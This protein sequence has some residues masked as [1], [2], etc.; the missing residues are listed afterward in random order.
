LQRL[1]ASRGG[2]A[3]RH[4]L[5]NLGD[6]LDKETDFRWVVDY[7]TSVIEEE[8]DS[9]YWIFDAVRKQQQVLNFRN[10]FS[11]SIY[12]I[13]FVAPEAEL[14]RRYEE[15]QQF[16]GLRETSYDSAVT[17]LNEIEA[18]SLGEVADLVLSTAEDAPSDV[19]RKAHSAVIGRKKP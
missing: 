18:R 11:A 12:H 15:R 16:R 19:A 6:S 4:D 2:N 5:Q 8:P 14:R 7:A 10:A 3:T 17:H 9:L 13:H 1:A